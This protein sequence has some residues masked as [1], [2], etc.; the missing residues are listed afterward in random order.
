L[1]LFYSNLFSKRA[2]AY[3]LGNTILPNVPKRFA[4]HNPGGSDNKIPK[5]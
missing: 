1:K 2:A 3:R 4:V 5:E